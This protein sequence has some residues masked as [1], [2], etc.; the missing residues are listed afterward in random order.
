MSTISSKKIEGRGETAKGKSL[1]LQ[2]DR[3]MLPLEKSPRGLRKRTL[4]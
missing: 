2:N 3:P 4:R 1:D